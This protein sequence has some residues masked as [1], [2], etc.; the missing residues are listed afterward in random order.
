VRLMSRW[1]DEWKIAERTNRRSIFYLD[2]RLGGR[3]CE[4]LAGAIKAHLAVGAIAE[5]LVVAKPAAAEANRRAAGE[6]EGVAFCVYDVEVP[7]DTNGAVVENSY[8]S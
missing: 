1:G 6:V 4:C 3:E 2:L 8:F 7:F 5:G